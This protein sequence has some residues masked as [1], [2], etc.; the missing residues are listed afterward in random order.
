[1]LSK[2]SLKLKVQDVVPVAA[3]QLGQDAL[4]AFRLLLRQDP[5]PACIDID[6]ELTPEVVSLAVP[7]ILVLAPASEFGPRVPVVLT[8]ED[9]RV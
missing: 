1:M 2:A 9:G 4:K 6:I 8:D 3:N 5:A 7:V